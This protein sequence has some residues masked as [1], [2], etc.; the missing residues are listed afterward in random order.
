MATAIVQPIAIATF[1]GDTGQRDDDVAALVVAVIARI[2][3]DRLGARED[4]AMRQPAASSGQYNRHPRVNVLERIPGQATKLLGRRV[5]L[6]QRGV[7][8]RVLVRDDREEQDR[9]DE[10]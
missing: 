9:C 8:V 5:P 6:L 1:V 7:P 2:D 3:R 4:R 10:E